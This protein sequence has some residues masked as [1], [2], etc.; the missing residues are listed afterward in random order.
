MTSGVCFFNK[1]RSIY[2]RFQIIWETWR[3]MVNGDNHLWTKNRHTWA[4]LFFV[5]GYLRLRLS[6]STASPLS[7]FHIHQ[8]WYL[9]HSR[10][11]YRRYHSLYE[12]SVDWINLNIPRSWNFFSSPLTPPSLPAAV[13]VKVNMRWLS[14]DPTPSFKLN[15]VSESF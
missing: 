4:W 9:H 6:I 1:K 12:F 13:L 8:I 7:R 14:N 2:Y 11:S 5:K 10:R 3:V 15:G